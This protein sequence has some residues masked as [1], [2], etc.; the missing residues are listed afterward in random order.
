MKK[1]QIVPGSNQIY[2]FHGFKFNDERR[3]FAGYLQAGA[4]GTKT[5]IINIKTGKIDFK[6]AQDNAEMINH[7]VR[8]Y[9]PKDLNEGVAL[10]HNYKNVGVKTLLYSILGAEFGRV[11]G[12][13]LQMNPLAYGKAYSEWEKAAAKE[14]KLVRFKGMANYEDQIANLGH[15]EQELIIKSTRK[16]KLGQLSDYYTAGTKQREA[17]E[18]LSPLCAEIK[19]VVELGGKKRTFRIGANP[20]QQVCEIELD[21]SEVPVVA[22]NPDPDSLHKWC[23]SLLREFVESIYPGMGIKP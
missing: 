16:N 7:Y 8:F 5:D 22:G 4:Y 11:T 1:Y 23:G 2:C 9:V 12:R 21:E 20:N 10:L 17:I 15:S 18:M 19:T 13:V 6:K 14:I 3:Q